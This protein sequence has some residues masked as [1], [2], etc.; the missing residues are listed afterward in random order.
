MAISLSIQP[1]GQPPETAR[2][3]PLATQSAFD[4]YWAPAADALALQWIPMFRTGL[5]LL[6]EDLDSVVG[7]L[8][9]LEKRIQSLGG[10]AAESVLPR[11]GRILAE[12]ELVRG[13][14]G[15]EL[16]IG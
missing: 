10:E 12:L 16:Y 11:V 1:K 7:E 9:A 13:D 15:V 4:Q 5:P 6:Q 2:T 8:K 14:D 3:V